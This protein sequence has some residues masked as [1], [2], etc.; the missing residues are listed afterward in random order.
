[1]M[2]SW[3]LSLASSRGEAWNPLEQIGIWVVTL[4][5][6]RLSPQVISQRIHLHIFMVFSGVFQFHHH[7]QCAER[8]HQSKQLEMQHLQ[9]NYIN[10]FA[11][12][13]M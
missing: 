8:L 5:I 11:V 2:I 13:G 9:A 4:V 12:P 1:M 3:A 6:K 7:P 10:F